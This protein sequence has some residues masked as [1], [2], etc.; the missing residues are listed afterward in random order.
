ME[1][2]Q[3]MSYPAAG[4]W[5]VKFTVWILHW[6]IQAAR[7][8]KGLFPVITATLSVYWLMGLVKW[9]PQVSMLL[10]PSAHTQLPPWL[11]CKLQPW[12]GPTH[13]D[14]RHF[15]P[16]KHSSHWKKTPTTTPFSYC[17]SGCLCYHGNEVLWRE[18]YW[19]IYLD[20][21][22]FNEGCYLLGLI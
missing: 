5:Y 10:L 3:E 19:G 11:C 6:N 17:Q 20:F 15:P 22:A 4:D 14:N 13:K 21:Y 9:C 1:T 2:W 18:R 12:Y 16:V 8:L 7:E